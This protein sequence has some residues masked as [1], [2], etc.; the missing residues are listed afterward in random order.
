MNVCTYIHIHTTP[1]VTVC[2][3]GGNFQKSARCSIDNTTRTFQLILFMILRI[4]G[5]RHSNS[6]KSACCSLERAP[7]LLRLTT[8]YQ[9]PSASFSAPMC[10]CVLACTHVFCCVYTHIFSN[11]NFQYHSNVRHVMPFTRICRAATHCNTLQHTATHCNTLHHTA[12]HC[13]TLQ[14]TATHCN[15]LQHTATHCITLQLYFYY[16]SNVQF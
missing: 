14:H 3:S 9:V 10:V 8:V 5:R 11:R 15:T 4:R 13:N 7:L 6:Q 12:T 2:D 1:P 16:H